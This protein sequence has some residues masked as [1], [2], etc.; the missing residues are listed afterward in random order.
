MSRDLNSLLRWSIENAEPPPT[1]NVAPL[2]PKKFDSGIVDAV[3]GKSD[4]ARM[5]ECVEFIDDP[6]N[7]A[8]AKLSAWDE[9]EMIIESGDNA[10][11]LDKM[12]LWPPICKHL[13]SSDDDTL[14]QALWVCGTA[15]NNNPTAQ[16]AFLRHDPL[17]TLI[18]L[19]G[20]ENRNA[21]VRSKALYCL[22][23]TLKSIA[24]SSALERFAELDGWTCLA[25]SLKDPSIVC[26]R[27]AAFLIGSL[28]TSANQDV[29]NRQLF[30]ARSSNV[31][32][33][34]VDSLSLSTTQPFGPN[35]DK[36]SDEDFVEKVANALHRIA[37]V[38][39]AALS[40]AEQAR[41]LE[42]INYT[43]FG[44]SDAD[45]EWLRNVLGSSTSS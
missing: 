35:G 40:N 21:E 16:E 41:V 30:K 37:R 13:T 34:L 9:L 7:S 6:S 43:N 22:S 26:R 36:V 44:M 33:I 29:A 10:N 39:S 31:I 28:F 2:Q 38:D 23:G 14:V 1:N 12:N 3:L 25:Q 8:D 11:D 27:K 15:I 19:P 17:P 5:K 4:A 18:A 24:D 45:V 20:S 42:A 32:P